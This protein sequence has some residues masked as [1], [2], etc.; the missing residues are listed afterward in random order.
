MTFAEI[1]REKK[2][3]LDDLK[4]RLRPGALDGLEHTHRIDITYASNAIEGNT[5]TAGETAL[6]VEKGLTIGGKPMKDHLEAIDHARALDWVLEIA[7]QESAR[8][9]ETDIRNLHRLIVAQSNPEIAGRYAVRARFVNTSSGP[10]HFPA[11]VEIPALMDRF[12]NWLGSQPDSPEIAFAAHRDLVA[13]HPFDDGNGRTARLL[14]NLILARAG[15]PSIAV[16][17]ENRPT[18][19]ATLEQTDSDSFEQLMY[20]HLDQTLT[21]YLLAADQALAADAERPDKD[22]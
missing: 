9:R 12:C 4:R 5:L 2:R 18:Y 16:R 8:I 11:P 22:I 13:I 10:F 14:M 6:V 1:V 20:R 17:P 19:I 7:A 21:L 15:F 3:E